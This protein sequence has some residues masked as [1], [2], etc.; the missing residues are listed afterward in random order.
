MSSYISNIIQRHLDTAT[1]IMPRLPSLYETVDMAAAEPATGF[2]H[3]HQTNQ[4][5]SHIKNIA[6]HTEASPLT[7]E[8]LIDP[9]SAKANVIQT[10]EY[11]RYAQPAN[12]ITIPVVNN[13]TADFH[14][15]NLISV[16]H[17]DNIIHPHP[18]QE[19][20]QTLLNTRIDE[21][22]PQIL[23][24]EQKQ[25]SNNVRDNI[26]MFN[27]K[28]LMQERIPLSTILVPDKTIPVIVAEQPATQTS[29]TIIRVSIGKI[30][31]KAVTAATTVKPATRETTNR[32]P[33]LSLNDYLQQRNKDQK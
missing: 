3:Q 29:S 13:T 18:V 10:Q 8:N 26:N 7:K 9:Q 28:P 25:E 31:V 24:K 2:S 11:V 27:H 16:Q 4:V 6:E 23:Q 17:Y 15:P 22:I 12:E 21:G 20:Q 19:H 32:Q 14:P 30:E 33:V 5:I 1:H